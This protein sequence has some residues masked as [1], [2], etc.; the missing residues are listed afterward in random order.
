MLCELFIFVT[1]IVERKICDAGLRMI[2]GRNASKEEFPYVVRLEYQMTK[3][4]DKETQ[5]QYIQFCTGA[6]LTPSWI[7]TAAHCD[8]PDVY[9]VFQPITS[10]PIRKFARFNS[11]L[12]NDLGSMS[13]ITKVLAYPGALIDQLSY[14]FRAKYDIALFQ[15]ENITVSRYGRISAIDFTS[16]IGHEVFVLGFGLTNASMN[17]K[18]MQ[19]FKG[20]LIKC[21]ANLP[22]V[23]GLANML[24][25][26]ASCDIEA[27][28]CSGDSGGPTVHPTG[29]VGVTSAGWV[30][31]Y[32]LEGS[33][34]PPVYA[35]AAI[36]M[37]SSA[38]DWISN[39]IANK[40][41]Q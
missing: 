22:F 19:V 35:S 36:S 30:D 16:L 7:L 41:T 23:N 34:L 40:T 20:I 38:I 5:V 6:A 24:C 8:D 17:G 29:I 3:T 28:L 27:T 37:T 13:P 33:T 15:T 25:V 4:I 39:V 11:H 12:P 26:V 10:K 32:K 9:K 21:G 18:P 14:S 31:C 1:L 2:G